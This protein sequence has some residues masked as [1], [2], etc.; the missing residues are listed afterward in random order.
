V[1][2]DTIAAVSARMAACTLDS[3]ER[4]ASESIPFMSASAIA[5]VSAAVDCVQAL[6]CVGYRITNNPCPADD[7][8]VDGDTL[9]SCRGSIAYEIDCGVQ[10]VNGGPSCLTGSGL[11]SCGEGACSNEG[12]SC[13]GT[14]RIDCANGVR[15]EFDCAFLGLECFANATGAECRTVGEVCAGGDFCDGDEVVYCDAEVEDRV[16]CPE[17]VPGTTCVGSA[18]DVSCG[19]DDSCV[20][21][22]GSP[23]DNCAGDQLEFCLLGSPVS[24]S[25]TELGFS[26]CVSDQLGTGCR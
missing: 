4:F 24:V 22:V 1:D 11:S 9:L 2:S 18:G 16:S 19:F 6:A 7:T 17:L 10:E 23:G 8:C 14:V 12:S 26:G 21:D 3:A 25:C 5:C 20:P 15:R 13:Q